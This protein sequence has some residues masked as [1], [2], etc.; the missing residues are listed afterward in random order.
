MPQIDAKDLDYSPEMKAYFEH[1]LD[2]LVNGKGKSPEVARGM[3]DRYFNLDVDPLERALVMHC[4][5]EHV[6]DD[7]AHMVD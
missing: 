3:I 2:I 1:V 7:L 5:P 4:D 6:A